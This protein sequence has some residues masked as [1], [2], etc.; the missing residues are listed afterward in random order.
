M[1]SVRF[2]LRDQSIARLQHN[3]D[4]DCAEL[5]SRS[6]KT[7]VE[8]SLFSTLRAK[9]QTKLASKRHA[10]IEVRRRSA[11]GALVLRLEESSV[12]IP[13][14]L[15]TIV[16]LLASITNLA[17]SACYFQRLWNWG[18][19][20]M[21][22]GCSVASIVTWL[23]LA[24]VSHNH[25][26]SLFSFDRFHT[27]GSLASTHKKELERQQQENAMFALRMFA[28]SPLCYAVAAIFYFDG[29]TE[30]IWALRFASLL[31]LIGSYALII[32]CL[33]GSM[34]T[35]HSTS[36]FMLRSNAVIQ[37]VTVLSC[38]FFLLSAVINVNNIFFL[39]VDDANFMFAKYPTHIGSL[40]GTIAGSLFVVNSL[41]IEWAK[42][43]DR[44]SAD[45]ESKKLVAALPLDKQRLIYAWHGRVVK[46]M[47]KDRLETPAYKVS[48]E[49]GGRGLQRFP[50][51]STI[52]R[53]Q[54][55]RAEQDASGSSRLSRFSN[56]FSNR[57][58][59]RLSSGPRWSTMGPMRSNGASGTNGS[60]RTASN[61]MMCSLSNRALPNIVELDTVHIKAN[62]EEEEASSPGGLTPIVT[63]RPSSRPRTRRS[64]HG[65][66][67]GRAQIEAAVCARSSSVPSQRSNPPSDG[68]E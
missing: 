8:Q 28:F 34:T 42:R 66:A 49:E 38:S 32:G 18:S 20:L 40:G 35:D 29:V 17:G 27:E 14:D 45:R 16:H 24:R 67:Y 15:L 39:S 58:S 11:Q 54:L 43:H 3:H 64:T 48:I 26:E 2:L 13:E 53:I 10:A 31:F 47:E 21:G 44:Q 23:D 22:S 19:A 50:G 57:V 55:Q 56:R 46:R 36:R 62:E 25:F 5:S 51:F 59:N 9:E 33:S 61:S 65:L 6:C 52:R 7:L 4:L 60:M 1:G 37:Q 12:L 63:V 30:N 68:E 41:F